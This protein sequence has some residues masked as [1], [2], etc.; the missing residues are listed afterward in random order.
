MSLTSVHESVKRRFGH[1]ITLTRGADS[2]VVTASLH[3]DSE[4]GLA[5]SATQNT[6]T[7][8]LIASELAGTVLVIPKM[9]DKLTDGT[10]NK[11]VN[12]VE[13]IMAA[14]DSGQIIGWRLRVGG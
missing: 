13:E 7:Y 10:Q 2:V 5:G 3:R 1:K 12:K 9:K 11:T 14:D 4:S 6:P 8:H